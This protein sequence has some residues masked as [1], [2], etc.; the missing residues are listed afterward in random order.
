MKYHPFICLCHYIYF[1]IFYL[2]AGTYVLFIYYYLLIHTYYY[3]LGVHF[4][5]SYINNYS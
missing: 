3:S 2:T 4:T 1:D 5:L